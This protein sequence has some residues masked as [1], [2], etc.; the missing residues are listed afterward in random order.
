MRFLLFFLCVATM[1][2][3]A[4]P[5]SAAGEGKQG[6]DWQ[7]V[8]GR[9]RDL[10]ISSDGTVYAVGLDGRVYQWD[11]R[12]FKGWRK[13]AGRL[14]RISVGPP[15]LIRGVD[16]K[17][18][19]LGYRNGRWIDLNEQVRGVVVGASGHVLVLR[20][21]GALEKWD[22]RAERWIYTGAKGIGAAVTRAGVPWLLQADGSLSRLKGTKW[23]PMPG[24][25]HAAIDVA[26]GME[27]AVMAACRDGR[28][29]Q[30]EESKGRWSTLVGNYR[31][32]R[33]ALGPGDRPWT[34]DSEGRI[35]ASEVFTIKAAV[36]GKETGPVFRFESYQF[37]RVR[38]RGRSLSIGADGTVFALDA[39]D[40][41]V[42][43]W[44]Q[45][46]FGGWAP[47]PGKLENIAVDPQGNPW[48]IDAKGVIRRH[49]GMLWKEVK[50]EARD[51][52]VGADGT[53]FILTPDGTPARWKP[54]GGAWE[55]IPGASGKSLVVDQRGR[56]WLLA[57][58][59]AILR[60]DGKKWS[61]V[62]GKAAALAIGPQGTV[63][64]A[65]SDGLLHVWRQARER[66]ETVTKDYRVADVAVGPGGKPWIIA[67]DGRIYATSMFTKKKELETVARAEAP[68]EKPPVP[69][70]TVT[71][72]DPIQWTLV[73]G[74]GQEIGIG[75]EGHVF[76]VDA[77]GNLMR[78]DTQAGRFMSFGRAFKRVAV[79]GDGNPWGVEA[80]GDLLRYDGTRWIMLSRRARDIAIGWDGSVF[81]VD[82]DSGRLYR[83]VTA[84]N[85][86]ES[87]RGSGERVA[88]DPGGIPWVV[89]HKG[90]VRRC[91]EEGC[92]PMGASGVDIGIGPDGTVVVTG[93]GAGD[94]LRFVPG[95]SGESGEWER[96]PGARNAV[97]VSVGPQGRPWYVDSAGRIYSS[98]FF[99]I[100]E[101]SRVRVVRTPRSRPPAIRF[102]KTLRMDLA[103]QG[104]THSGLAT[105]PGQVF[106]THMTK[107]GTEWSIYQWNARKKTFERYQNGSAYAFNTQPR[108]LAVARNGRLWFIDGNLRV[109]EETAPGRGFKERLGVPT[110]GLGDSTVVAAGG[111]GSVF[112]LGKNGK[113][114][115]Y[116]EHR[117]R[118]EDFGLQGT[119]EWLAVDQSG[120]PWITDAASL[121]LY[122]YLDGELQEPGKRERKA[123]FFDFGP[124]GTLFVLD[125]TQKTLFRWN[126][127]NRSFDKVNL[128]SVGAD[129]F[130]G[131][132][133]V[134]DEGEPWLQEWNTMEVFRVK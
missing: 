82:R 10:A 121:R 49:S 2:W 98:S 74:T 45:D 40:G 59:G 115:I 125:E 51:V 118:F 3:P 63:M 13:I 112:V 58:D 88:V 96:L 14:S 5:V 120:N 81:I 106:I 108:S 132:V 9:A 80:D 34:I 86:F 76:T 19:L 79:D 75:A 30:W 73:P 28:L 22:Q 92:L 113:V 123:S 103:F 117:K 68:V 122:R 35:Y 94:L 85:R 42:W 70:E 127:T 111:D 12:L 23:E 65:D 36:K 101:D 11:D 1:T 27:G 37:R 66:W 17:G 20:Q 43:K 126:S 116:D 38:G 87:Q 15:D 52:A 44:K 97:A 16:L 93:A 105:G 69:P 119:Y 131:E 26:A 18:R 129:P 104:N 31:A 54:K 95:P 67:G 109:Y 110:T 6:L 21:D 100:P 7:R 60:H 71:S 64:M 61:S 50:G 114:Y 8:D 33:L 57:D 128:R 84:E 56:P 77:E 133:A 48:G 55:T 91:G 107:P 99:D 32:E 78:W 90:S 130:W 25:P 4:A 41:R 102:E 124:T 53:V 39:R 83:Y 47:F 24:P 62:L 89:D 29:R 46:A 72:T 134:D